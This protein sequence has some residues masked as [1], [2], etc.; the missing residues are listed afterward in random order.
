MT[1]IF[2][3]RTCTEKSL[4]GSW[5]KCQLTMVLCQ[6]QQQ[7]HKATLHAFLYFLNFLE[8]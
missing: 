3:N 2:V 7:E 6:Q 4:E 8:S 5:L 1:P